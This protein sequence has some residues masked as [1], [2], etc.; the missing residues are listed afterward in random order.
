MRDYFTLGPTPT[1]EACA[2]V[3]E[4]DY[5]DRARAECTRFI[6]LLRHTFGPEPDG[7]RLATKW[8]DHDFGAYCEVV[9]WFDTDIPESVD[10]A[11]RCDD[12]TPATWEQEYAP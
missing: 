6:A 5:A 12:E 1:D 10:Y 7:A 8:F 9:V 4:E 2:Q 3:G 11:H